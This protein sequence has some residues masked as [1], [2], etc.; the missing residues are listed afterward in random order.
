MIEIIDLT[1]QFRTT[2]A[3]KEVNMSIKHGDIYGFVGENGAGKSTLIKIIANVIKPTSG[4]VK[5]NFDNTIGSIQAIVEEPSLHLDLTAINNLRFQNDLFDLRKTDEE[6]KD[7]LNLVGL[8]DVIESKKKAKHFSLGMKQRLSI[9]MSLLPSPKIILLDEPMNGLD[10][11]GIKDIRELILK[12]NQEHQI[13]FLISS[14]ILLELDRV[15]TKYGFISKGVLVEEITY[16]DLHQKAGSYIKVVYQ[17]DITESDLE[18][19]KKY[20]YSK[21]NSRTIHIAGEVEVSEVMR[22]LVNNDVLFNAVEKVSKS[23]ED[24]YMEIIRGNGNV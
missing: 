10:P 13:T 18:I 21:I 8:S 11:V 17:D 2:T 4:E 23:I 12:L 7:V 22:Y 19:L 15:A 9:A 14:H 6:L 3:L 16:Q 24:F 20:Q 5:F 1:K